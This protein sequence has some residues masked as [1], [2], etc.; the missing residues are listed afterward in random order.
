MAENCVINNNLNVKY[1]SYYNISGNM[2]ITLCVENNCDVELGNYSRVLC[3]FHCNIN[4]GNYS[5]VYAGYKRM[6][7]RK[8]NGEKVYFTAHKP[9]GHL[10]IPYGDTIEVEYF[11]KNNIKGGFYNKIICK[12]NCVIEVGDNSTVLAGPKTVVKAGLNSHILFE[13]DGNVKKENLFQTVVVGKD[14]KPNKFYSLVLDEVFEETD[15]EV[16]EIRMW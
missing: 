9:D 11:S 4:V 13:Y 16:D 6:I 2:G 10:L 12:E 5:E 8:V 3:D 1:G 14:I 15:E 7:S